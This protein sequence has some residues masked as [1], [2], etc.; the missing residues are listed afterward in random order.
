M[1]NKLSLHM[2]KE[3]WNLISQFIKD[4]SDTIPDIL[5]DLISMFNTVFKCTPEILDYKEFLARKK[6][7]VSN[8]LVTLS[9]K[10]LLYPKEEHNWKLYYLDVYIAGIYKLVLKKII[11]KDGKYYLASIEIEEIM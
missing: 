5:K 1:E 4:I 3:L 10:R 2:N 6:I 8:Y 9:M 7:R 11:R